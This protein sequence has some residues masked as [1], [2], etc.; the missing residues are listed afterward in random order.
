L[1]N[2][3]LPARAD[4]LAAARDSPP[5]RTSAQMI[6]TVPSQQKQD[7]VLTRAQMRTTVPSQEKFDIV[8]TR[9]G[10]VHPAP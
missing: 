10:E 2:A 3:V 6:Y 7:I 9:E 1:A 8:L 4:A 5:G